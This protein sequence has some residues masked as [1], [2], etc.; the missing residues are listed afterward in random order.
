[1]ETPTEVVDLSLMTTDSDIGRS[2]E[3]TITAENQ[4]NY[5]PK[6]LATFST[7]CP[8]LTVK[9]ENGMDDQ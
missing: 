3:I 8:Q 5:D 2:L 1:M 7:M 9:E 4:L 6:W